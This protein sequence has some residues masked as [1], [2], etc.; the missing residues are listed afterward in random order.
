MS[1]KYLYL[2]FALALIFA[3]MPF[4]HLEFEYFIPIAVLEI[5]VFT[6][7]G[8]WVVEK[9]SKGKENK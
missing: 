8:N 5:L 9:I 7:A 3:M 6:L 4:K 1:P 2:V